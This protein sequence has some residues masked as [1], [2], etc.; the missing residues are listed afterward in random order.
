MDLRILSENNQI[1]HDHAA[2][3]FGKSVT[4]T[5]YFHDKKKLV[6]NGIIQLDNILS[7]YDGDSSAIKLP[8]FQALGKLRI[9]TL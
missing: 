5:K 4:T 1:L 9:K 6:L 7:N 3:E 8:I 2:G